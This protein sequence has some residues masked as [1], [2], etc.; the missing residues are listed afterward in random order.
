ML[1]YFVNDQNSVYYKTETFAGILQWAS[2]QRGCAVKDSGNK[3]WI[4]VP[5]VDSIER[6]QYCKSNITIFAPLKMSGKWL[7]MPEK[8]K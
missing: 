8:K 4:N 5:G 1:L 2:I 7:I 3:L 6:L